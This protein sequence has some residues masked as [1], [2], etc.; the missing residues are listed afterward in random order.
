M[1]RWGRK[2]FCG[3]NITHIMRND[4][5]KEKKTNRKAE[6]TQPAYFYLQTGAQRI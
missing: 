5:R 3:H 1:P 2:V 6:L 4:F